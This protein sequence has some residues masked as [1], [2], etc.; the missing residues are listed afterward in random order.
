MLQN[1]NS[2]MKITN[3]NGTVKHVMPTLL[4]LIKITLRRIYD[5]C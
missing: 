3:D 5:L 1:T 2:E 4:R